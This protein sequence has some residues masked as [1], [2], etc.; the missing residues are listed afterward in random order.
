[1]GPTFKLGERINFFFEILLLL[2]WFF[3]HNIT[4]CVLIFAPPL[5]PPSP[6]HSIILLIFPC[7]YIFRRRIRIRI[8]RSSFWN[9][10]SDIYWEALQYCKFAWC[11]Y[12][13]GKFVCNY[14]VLPI[15]KLE[16]VFE[17]KTRMLFVS[18]AHHPSRDEGF[19]YSWW[20]CFNHIPN[21]RRNGVFA[22]NGGMLWIS[23][24]FDLTMILE[25]KI[26]HEGCRK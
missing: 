10:G 15:R 18:V 12:K 19:T 8:Q 21:S 13:K 9:K 20:S 4:F 16:I 26:N 6:V 11:V 17:V 23:V 2:C 22:F 1:M 14:G 3:N 25:F 5:P 24:D 7:D